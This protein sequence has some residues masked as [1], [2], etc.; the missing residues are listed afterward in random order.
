MAIPGNQS[1]EM[2]KFQPPQSLDAEQA[3][4][5]S[6][7]KDDEAMSRVIEILDEES[8]FYFPKHQHIYRA[9]LDLFNRSEACD[10]TTVAN[11]LHKNG[12]LEKIG[13]RVYLVEL[14][15]AVASASNVD[16]YANIVLDKSL[17]RRLIS[18]SNEI[19]RTAYDLEMP[20]EDLLDAAESHIFRISESR[21]RNG[22]ISVKKL[23]PDTFQHIEQMQS[24]EQT[25]TIMTGYTE[26]DIMTQGLHKGDFVV[27]AGRPSMG[28]S[29]LAVNIAENIAI[30]AK[31]PVAIFSVEMSKEQLALRMLCGRSRISQQRLRSKKLTD[32]E[33]N[34]LTRA[35]GTLSMTDIFI[36]DSATLTSLQMR[37]KARRLKAQFPDLSLIIVDYMQMMHAS[38]HAENRQQELSAISRS[39]KAL[40]KELQLPVIACSQLSRMV[41]HRGGDKRPQLADLRESGAIEQDADVVMFVYRPEY[42]LNEDERNDPKNRD[43]IGVAEVIIAKQRNGPTGVA[44]MIFLKEFARFENP[45]PGY[46]ELPADVEPVGGDMPF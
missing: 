34:R 45:A 8:H 1:R 37:A 38:G 25:D 43:K 11:H 9:Y 30:N 35:G 15:E 6:V 39:M 28:K 41:E 24:G 26:L 14:V 10:I 32:E 16:A 13:G 22:F 5:G 46:R 7:L 36:D 31:K 18:T 12:Q 33:T 27:V 2:D 20:V 23:I 42:Y 17:L 40:A 21:L 4:L 29:A 44:H 3:V 19:S